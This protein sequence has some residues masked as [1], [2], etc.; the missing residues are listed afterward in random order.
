MVDRVVQAIH[1][2]LERHHSRLRVVTVLKRKGEN[3]QISKKVITSDSSEQ[4][5]NE[6][7][8]H[9]WRIGFHY[10]WIPHHHD[11]RND[12]CYLRPNCC[13]FVFEAGRDSDCPDDLAS[14]RTHRDACYVASAAAADDLVN[15]NHCRS[16]KCYSSSQFEVKT[17]R[18]RTIIEV[19]IKVLQKAGN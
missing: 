5:E 7:A 9:T 11:C 17:D 8:S 18:T 12:C 4:E 13:D 16:A 3:R 19:T 15:S 10:Y 1:E 14:F 6:L 2:V